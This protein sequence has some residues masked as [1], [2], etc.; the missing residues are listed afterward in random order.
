VPLLRADGVT[1]LF[2]TDAEWSAY[3]DATMMITKRRRAS[4]D[5]DHHQ[6][7][8][9]LVSPS[10]AAPFDVGTHLECLGLT[11]SAEIGGGGGGFFVVDGKY[12]PSS[13]WSL[14]RCGQT[15]R[16]LKLL[17]RVTAI[18]LRVLSAPP[19]LLLAVAI[20]FPNDDDDELRLPRL[21]LDADNL[22][23]LSIRFAPLPGI[24]V[25]EEEEGPGDMQQ[26]FDACMM[27]A[28]A[29]R[30][31]PRPL[32]LLRFDAEVR[33]A[34]FDDFILHFLLEAT[35]PPAGPRPWPCRIEGAQVVV[36]VLARSQ[37]NVS[38]PDV[39]IT[40]RRVQLAHV[41]VWQEERAVPM[42]ALLGVERLELLGGRH[43]GFD[44]SID[45]LRTDAF[46]GAAE[47][48][49]TPMTLQC[50]HSILVLDARP[51]WLT[52]VVVEARSG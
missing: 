17:P 43:H 11:A 24:L 35:A 39:P 12:T 38:S 52:V 5:G 30:S 15:L 14:L 34:N 47:L 51:A 42:M 10:P 40:I 37:K 22:C 41:G 45:Q 23:A 21:F 4:S 44:A 49:T 26:L 33:C 20:D 27:V 8:L 3:F 50:D 32:E 25:M 7:H 16:R 19:S 36:W 18:D 48:R 1:P 46:H 28:H 29:V 9:H 13:T 2:F 31:L 6:H